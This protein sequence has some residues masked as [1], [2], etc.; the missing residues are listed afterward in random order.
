MYIDFSAKHLLYIIN[1]AE[2]EFK[3][4]IIQELRYK[5]GGV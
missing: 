3:T 5:V 2:Y 1:I 4:L